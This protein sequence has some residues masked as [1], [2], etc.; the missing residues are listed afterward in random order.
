MNGPKE[1]S[2]IIQRTFFPSYGKSMKLDLECQVRIFDGITLAYLI[3]KDHNCSN[4]LS[5]K[6]TLDRIRYYSQVD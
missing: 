5:R 1:D 4:I 3:S 6:G 2:S